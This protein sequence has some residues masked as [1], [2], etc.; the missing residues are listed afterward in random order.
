MIERIVEWLVFMSR[1]LLVPMYLGLAMLLPVF[2]I[3]FFEEFWHI[4]VT[5]LSSGE[6]DGVVA[7]V[8]LLDLVLVANLQVRHVISVYETF[9][10]KIDLREDDDRPSWLGKID[11]G[12]LKIKVAASIVAISS[13]HLLRAFMN[14][15][16]LTN[17]KVMWLVLIH[18]AFVVSALLLAYVDRIAFKDK[19]H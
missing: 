18:I 19:G 17:D 10:S 14:I 1:W 5:V 4:A 3:K 2:T 12:T 11:A 6:G 7:A 9:V 16:T 13:I 15:H 8:E